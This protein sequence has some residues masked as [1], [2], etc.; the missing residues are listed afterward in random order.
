MNQQ[1]TQLRQAH[2]YYKSSEADFE[3]EKAWIWQDDA[4]CAFL[5]PT[6]FEV[7]FMGDPI[8][9]GLTEEELKDLNS[10]NLEAA[11]KVCSTCPMKGACAETA[12]PEDFKFTMRA[13]KMPTSFSPA[14]RGRPAK[15]RCPK[16]HDP[17]WGFKS[18][19]KYRTCLT[20]RAEQAHARNIAR[21]ANSP[22]VELVKGESR[23]VTC[24]FNHD[25]WVK[26]HSNGGRWWRC[27]PCR[28]ERNKRNARKRRE[29]DKLAS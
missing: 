23:G 4:A 11:A 9:E 28:R 2:S 12:S 19:T 16:D 3:T 14:K 18:G 13:G 29:A 26:D 5:P 6:M 20:C 25:E 17:N 15:E 10:A 1:F 24:K 7:A 21:R 27:V 22:K 8:A